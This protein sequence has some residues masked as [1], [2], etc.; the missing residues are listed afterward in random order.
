MVCL[1]H[2]TFVFDLV[3]TTVT[4]VT[5][6]CT[7]EVVNIERAAVSHLN[8]GGPDTTVCIQ[9]KADLPGDLAVSD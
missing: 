4:G 3:S 8:V 1:I 2:Y 5:A 6:R 9:V 7:I